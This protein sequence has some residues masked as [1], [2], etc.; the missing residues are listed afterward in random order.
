[1]IHN[2]RENKEKTI[3]KG[4]K[5]VLLL[6]ISGFVISVLCM[7]VYGNLFQNQKNLK[8]GTTYMTMNN[9]FYK[10]AKRN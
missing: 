5:F 10:V 3:K 1:M 4:N 9:D 6:I 2:M 8:I 7:S